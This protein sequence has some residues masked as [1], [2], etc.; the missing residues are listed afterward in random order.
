M[1]TIEQKKQRLADMA[2]RRAFTGILVARPSTTI[3][4]IMGSTTGPIYDDKAAAEKDGPPAGL[5]Q[6]CTFNAEVTAPEEVVT[7]W[8]EQ[9][10]EAKAKGEEPSFSGIVAA[11]FEKGC[12][13]KERERPE[14]GKLWLFRTEQRWGWMF[15]GRM[16]IDIADYIDVV[17]ELAGGSVSVKL[18]KIDHKFY[19]GLCAGIC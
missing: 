2:A 12:Y 4:D 15:F 1:A 8:Q 7:R 19:R 17:E 5:E 6:L 14:D 10:A 16:V 11:W 18:K 3:G 13:H 9:L